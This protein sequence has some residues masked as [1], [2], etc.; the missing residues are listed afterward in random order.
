MED[1]ALVLESIAGSCCLVATS[2]ISSPCSL[3]TLSRVNQLT[4]CSLGG[5]DDTLLLLFWEL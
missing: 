5:S 2:T 1:A 3:I 4:L